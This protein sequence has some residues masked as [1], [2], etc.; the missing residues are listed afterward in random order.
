MQ[1]HGVLIRCGLD[2]SCPWLPLDIHGSQ[3]NM[4]RRLEKD[5]SRVRAGGLSVRPPAL[6]RGLGAAWLARGALSLV[7]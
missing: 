2:L 3:G 4:Q 1:T 7:H 6:G 5:R